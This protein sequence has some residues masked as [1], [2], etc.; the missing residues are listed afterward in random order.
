[1]KKKGKKIGNTNIT[2]WGSKVEDELCMPS[3]PSEKDR[4]WKEVR[5]REW[6]YTDHLG[7]TAERLPEATSGMIRRQNIAGDSR[8]PA[9]VDSQNIWEI[10]FTI[11]KKKKKGILFECRYVWSIEMMEIV[12][13]VEVIF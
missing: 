3:T 6:R 8:T 12:E 2:Q 5:E 10:W 9:E 1:M 4:M 13:K 7:G 11:N